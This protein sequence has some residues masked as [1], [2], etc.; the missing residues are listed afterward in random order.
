MLGGFRHG[1]GIMMW[2]DGAKFQGNWQYGFAN[3]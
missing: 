1:N 3:G 2:P